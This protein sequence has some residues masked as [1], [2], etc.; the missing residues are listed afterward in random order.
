MGWAALSSG[1]AGQRREQ[2]RSFGS[3]A[4]ALS[5]LG[6]H[7][8]ARDSY[9]HALQAA[10]D[11]GACEALAGGGV[12][13]AEGPWAGGEADGVGEGRASG[14]RASGAGGTKTAP[15]SPGDTKGQWQACEG[16]GAAA[17][18]LGQHAQALEYYKDALARCQ[19]RPRQETRLLRPGPRPWPPTLRPPP[20]THSLSTR[21]A[22]WLLEPRALARERPSV[23]LCP[24]CWAGPGKGKG[25]A[26]GKED[27]AP[28]PRGLPAPPAG[29]RK[30]KHRPP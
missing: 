12:R 8:A 16:L 28:L 23:C 19:V 2:G 17:A 18:R 10:Q 3:L 26:S 21:W 29:P 24:W 25:W 22:H 20:N 5:Q 14:G 9:L 13:K 27:R 6:D 11:A 7:E 30:P 15:L 1:S 4:F